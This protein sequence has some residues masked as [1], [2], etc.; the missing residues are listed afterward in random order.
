MSL[1]KNI[2][3]WFDETK[4]EGKN[5]D[6][7]FTG[8][9]SRGFLNGFMFLIAS[10]H[11][12][13]EK[14]SQIES[15]LH[16]IAYICLTLRDC[17]SLFNRLDISDVQVMDL[18]QQCQRFFRIYQ[19]FIDFHPTVWHLGHVVPVHVKEMKAKYD[20]GLGLNSM[21]GRESKHVS[22]ARYSSNTTQQSRWPPTTRSTSYIPERALSDPNYCY[23]GYH[24]DPSDRKCVFCLH[25]HRIKI[26]QSVLKG[27]NLLTSDGI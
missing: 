8:K 20:L 10:V 21:E 7:R 4:G 1:A 19:L 26:L 14:G 15:N 18:E 23:C 3:K 22:I 13:A 27:K 2:I 9:E 12:F 25:P 17:V 16:I 5:F 6:V 11:C 24:K